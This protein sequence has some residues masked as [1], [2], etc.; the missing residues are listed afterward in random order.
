VPQHGCGRA[1]R[2][3][4]L[5]GAG[6]RSCRVGC[7]RASSPARAPGEAAPASRS[8]CQAARLAPPAGAGWP[9]TR[10]PGRRSWHRLSRR[11]CGLPARRCRSQRSGAA[12]L[13]L[14]LVRSQFRVMRSAAPALLPVF[15]PPPQA[16]ILAAVLLSPGREYGLTESGS[17]LRRA[18]EHGARRGAVA[19][20]SSRGSGPGAGRGVVTGRPCP[21]RRAPGAPAAGPPGPDSCCGVA[22]CRMRSS[23]TR[24]T[25]ASSRAWS[26]SGGSMPASGG[27]SVRCCGRSCSSRGSVCAARRSGSSSAG[28]R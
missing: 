28:G 11:C 25:P 15:R 26:G 2:R 4:W 1:L 12:C 27:C 8:L 9:R 7:R 18:A 3:R 6:E 21:T 13:A 10:R 24:A 23:S 17:T 22:L 16:D 19:D 14:R 20:A 5:A